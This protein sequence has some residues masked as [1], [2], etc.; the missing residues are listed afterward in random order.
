M[1]CLNDRIRIRRK[2]LG[3]TLLQL[4]DAIGAKE[5]TVQ[6]W[7]SGNTRTVKY[8]TV[9]K[10][11]KVLHCSP[12]YLMGWDDKE[13]PGTDDD[14]GLHELIDIVRALSPENR[15]KLVELARLY[16]SAQHNTEES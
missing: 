10:L 13:N 16:L 5:A 12:A 7:E 4:A 15:A 6:R 2:E 14:A 8:E 9:E 11:S 3:M 1:A